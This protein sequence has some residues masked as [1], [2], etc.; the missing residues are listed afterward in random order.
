MPTQAS[1]AAVRE[2]GAAAIAVDITAPPGFDAQ[3]GQFVKLTATV[4]GEDRSRFFS[5][6]SPHVDETFEVTIE[7]D[8]EG[9]LGPWLAERDPGDELRVDGPFGNTFYEQEDR[10]VLLAGGPGVGPAVGIAE[11]ALDDDNEAA[12]I[13]RHDTLIHGDRLDWLQHQDVYVAVLDAEQ[14][15]VEA[16]QPALAGGGQV[17]IYGFAEFLDA[18]T[19]ALAAAGGEPDQAKLENFG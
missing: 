4:R 17:Y 13:Y 9:T 6:S 11:R 1:I 8:P 19:D 16:I 5:I 2:A 18:A 14:P 15:L 7:V 12:I 10:V 3:P